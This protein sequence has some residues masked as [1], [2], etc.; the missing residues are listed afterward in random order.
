MTKPERVLFVGTPIGWVSFGDFAEV[1]ATK[2]TFAAGSDLI[3][4]VVRAG[5]T[6]A[7][8]RP[9]GWFG[10]FYVEVEQAGKMVKLP[11]VSKTPKVS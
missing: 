7:E 10:Y 5:E 6:V 2:M 1:E 11:N 8:F 4:H 3:L 9:G